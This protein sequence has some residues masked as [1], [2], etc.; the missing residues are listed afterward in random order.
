[1][2]QHTTLTDR[3]DDLLGKLVRKSITLNAYRSPEVVDL[4]KASELL[5]GGA[6]TGK[7]NF[8]QQY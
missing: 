7:D 1:M 5:Q 8:W 3:A 2:E 4:G 6:Y